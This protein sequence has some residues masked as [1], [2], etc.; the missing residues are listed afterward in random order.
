MLLDTYAEE[1]SFPNIYC[2]YKKQLNGRSK[3]SYTE[4]VLSE[5]QRRDRRAVE[6]DH[7]LYMHKNCHLIQ[8]RNNI[9]TA[10]RKTRR[11]NEITVNDILNNEG[12]VE[13]MI[14]NVEGY[15]FLKNIT[16]SPVY[17][18]EQKKNVMGMIRTLGVPTLFITLSAAE[19]HWPVLLKMLKKTLDNEED[20]NVENMPF[21]EKCRLIK[22]DPVTCVRYFDHILKLIIKQEM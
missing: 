2:G 22:G 13:N 6:A 19:T 11:S 16:W 8:I 7:L 12:F 9:S 1:L 3:L 14:N 5:I 21:A 18:E 10:L 4:T 20:A 17:F 15:H